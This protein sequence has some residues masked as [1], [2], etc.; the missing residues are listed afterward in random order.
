MHNSSRSTARGQMF[1]CS[2][3]PSAGH[4]TELHGFMNLMWYIRFLLSE[5]Y[6]I[7]LQH[8]LTEK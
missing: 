7:L 3:T 8:I 5:D 2:R 4:P 1:I 6:V